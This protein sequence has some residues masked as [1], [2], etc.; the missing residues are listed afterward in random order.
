MNSL[1]SRRQRPF[2]PAP[3]VGLKFENFRKVCENGLGD[4]HNSYAHSMA[5]FRDHLYVGITRS[6]MCM[7]K[8]Q[9]AYANTELS[10]WPVECPDTLDELYKLD[11]RA[12]IWRYNPVSSSWQQ[13]LRAPMINGLDNKPVTREIGYR[14]MAVYRGRSD[15]ETVLYV[16][17]WAPGRAPGGLIIKSQDGE[18]FSRVSEYGIL[19]LPIQTT[20]TLVP[21]DGRLFFSP[22]ARKGSDGSQQNTSGLPVI[23]ESDDPAS[24]QWTEASPPGLGEPGNK[25]IFTLYPFG[26]QL[27]AGTFN[28]AGFQVWRSNCRGKRPYKWTKVIDQ[29]AFRGP[30]N[31]AVAAMK[32]SKGA[33][34]VGTGI[35]GGGRDRINNVGPDAS[36]LIR[37]FPDDSWDLNVGAP[38]NT[39]HGLNDSL[40]GL[41]PGFGNFFNGYIWCMEAHNGWLYAGTYDWSVNLQWASFE[42]SPPKVQQLIKVIGVDNIV[43][44][45][46]GFDLWRSW[47]GETW[48]PVNRQGFGNPYN[49]GVRNMVS[50]PHGLFVGTAN[51]FAPRVAVRRDGEWKYVDNPRGGLEV[52]LGSI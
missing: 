11:R 29:G 14:S 44:N 27:Y 26:D 19:G 8:L 48:L 43:N 33:L 21:F 32:A 9:S 6:N 51:V 52:W 3:N 28:L 16:S 45:Q 39:P 20:R 23:Y 40:S 22:T 12:Q 30:L 50:T 10:V 7:L 15:S 47:D 42:N 1:P 5:W 34:Y 4:G 13:V 24:G 17:T 46:G 18:H 2:D 38:R 37:I 31:Q 36:E 41:G 25:G 35:Q 49:W